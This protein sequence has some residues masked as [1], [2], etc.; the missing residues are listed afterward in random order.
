MFQRLDHV[1]IA[2]ADLEEAHGA[3]ARI[4]FIRRQEGVV[5]PDSQQ[6]YPGLN[7]RWAV[8]GFDATDRSI[9]LLQPLS[10][11]GPVHDF[12]QRHGPGVQHIAYAIADVDA[13][14][15]ALEALGVGLA[16]PN[17]WQDEDG[18]LSLFLAS[19]SVPGVLVELTQF[20]Q[21]PPNSQ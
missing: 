17:P 19:G 12:L 2:V 8:Y 6:G 7:A 9:V 10:A 14:K 13:T 21:A 20:S 1:G 3:L 16:R 4:G 15:A 11:H 5:G 18:H